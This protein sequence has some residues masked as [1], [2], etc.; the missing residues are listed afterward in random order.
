MQ[1]N[2]VLDLVLMGVYTIFALTIIN[3]CG[4]YASTI[5]VIIDK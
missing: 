5:Y 2:V 4:V 3:N 1:K